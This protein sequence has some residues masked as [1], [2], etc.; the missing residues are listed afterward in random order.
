[1]KSEEFIQEAISFVKTY[2]PE[3]KWQISPDCA[4]LFLD[5]E[6]KSICFLPNS[7]LNSMSSMTYRF[8][9]TEFHWQK[10][11]E[12]SKS[13]LC[14]LL[15]ITK[16]IHARQCII[17]R[18][19]K[20]IAGNFVN[21]NHTMGYASSY[22]NYGLFRKDILVAVACFSKGRRMNRL[23]GGERSF[24][25]I[26][27]C[28]LNYHTVVGGL[29]KLIHY[30]EQTHLPGDIMT[31]VDRAWGEP[32]AY[33]ALGFTLDKITPGVITKID[34]KGVQEI[35]FTNKGNYKLIKHIV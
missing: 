4:V 7:E 30:F 3:A 19:D 20:K 33:Y 23:P 18:I 10:N 21:E 28:N 22:Y 5:D 29:S 27:F 35:E 13:R 16:R 14:S 25:L 8:Y 26:R 9:I 31:Y 34:G 24:E 12:A 17:S 11:K 6:T 32:N 15:G 2:L 1:M